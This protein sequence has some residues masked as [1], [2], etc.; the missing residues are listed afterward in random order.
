MSHRQHVK[1]EVCSAFCVTLYTLLF[2]RSWFC[3]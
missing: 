1:Q 2:L 3:G